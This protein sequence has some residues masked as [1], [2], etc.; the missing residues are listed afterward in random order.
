MFVLVAYDV[1]ARRTAKYRRLLVKYLGH[2]QFSVF[3][4]DIIPTS[5]DPQ[6]W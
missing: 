5:G 1:D 4:G 2:E 3:F 6:M